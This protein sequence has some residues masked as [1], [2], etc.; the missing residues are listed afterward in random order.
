MRARI[1]LGLVTAACLAG[2]AVTLRAASPVINQT[3]AIVDATNPAAPN[4]AGVDA[5]GNLKV[6][7]AAGCA[8]SSSITGS[9]TNKSGTIA[10]GGAS[11]SLM[12]ANGSRKGFVIQNPCTASSQGIGAAENLV[13]NFTSSATITGG[14]SIEL[15]PCGSYAEFGPITTEAVTVNAATANHAYVAKE[16]N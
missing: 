12:A 2:A 16:L 1:L 7:C 15:T 14:N 5:S 4:Q 6:N 9:Y 11:Q 13:I 10:V 3:V 8:G